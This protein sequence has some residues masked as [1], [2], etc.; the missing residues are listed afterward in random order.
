MSIEDTL[1]SLAQNPEIEAV[2]RILLAAVIG[3]A[4][5][6]EREREGKPAGVR[7]YGGVAL[8][9]ATFTVLGVLLFGATDS[10]ARIAAQIITGVGFLGAGT[11]LQV[12]ARV[13]G[14]TTAAG[15]WV[16]AAI[17]MA[18]GFGLY[19]VG[20]GAGLAMILLVTLFDPDRFLGRRMRPHREPEEEAPGL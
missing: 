2:G 12:R 9:S 4:V 13:I 14:L 19:I 3:V 17:G 5:G 11:I 7:T 1:R 20:I 8:G 10:A 16:V 18:V 15:L 6:Y